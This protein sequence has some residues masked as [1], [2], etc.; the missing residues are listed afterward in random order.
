M[1][2][3]D[4]QT[5]KE[6]GIYFLIGAVACLVLSFLIFSIGYTGFFQKLITCLMPICIITGVV[7]LIASYR[8]K[9]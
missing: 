9:E 2:K 1:R 7:F 5:R 4:K 8:S 6:F 3:L